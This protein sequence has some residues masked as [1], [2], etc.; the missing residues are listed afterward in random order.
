M[1]I[2]KTR[3]FSFLWT[4]PIV[5]V[6]ETDQKNW[7]LFFFL[8]RENVCA[9]WP[10]GRLKKNQTAAWRDTVQLWGEGECE[11]YCWRECWKKEG[12]HGREGG[13]LARRRK[14]VPNIWGSITRCRKTG[15]F[16]RKLKAAK[17]GEVQGG[18]FCP[19]SCR[20]VCLAQCVCQ[21]GVRV[22]G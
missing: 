20:W 7:G 21:K 8:P 18:K 13:C 10:K 12:F 2:S 9:V 6:S 16:C 15:Q 14:A 1:L 22:I 11:D 5:V 3:V 19:G 17:G 4:H